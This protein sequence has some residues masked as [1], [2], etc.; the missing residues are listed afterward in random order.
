MRFHTS[1]CLLVLLALGNAL[2][3]GT[4]AAEARKALGGVIDGAV[5]IVVKGNTYLAAI[6]REYVGSF[7]K[8]F[9]L[10]KVGS[11][12]AQLFQR[13]V[14]VTGTNEWVGDIRLMDLNKDGFPELYV[15][16]TSCGAVM[17]WPPEVVFYDTASRKAWQFEVPSRLVEYPQELLQPK[18]KPFLDFLAAQVATLAPEE[19]P[20]PLGD[21]WSQ[22]GAI[23]Q[24]EVSFVKLEP[25]YAPLS[26]C[27][28]NSEYRSI[29]SQARVG[30]LEL[31]SYFKGD[32]VARDLKARR[33]FRVFQP[34]TVY[35]WVE[36]IQV[37][38]PRKVALVNRLD[39]GDVVYF[40][41]TTLTLSRSP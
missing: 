33:C 24:G 30:N 16:S 28:T 20:D 21:W 22:Y 4:P 36:P 13:E 40:D 2:G 31:I 5:R 8:V 38:S 19:P 14:S 18:F 32:V 41:P 39:P 3:Q 10:R 9:L 34:K 26:A 11:T 35:D 27:P 12:Y 15:T 23:S 7:P 29:V 6:R 17:C 37:L 1:L 25:K